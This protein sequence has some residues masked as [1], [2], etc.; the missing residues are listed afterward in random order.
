MS[1]DQSREERLAAQL[2]ANLRKRKA[3]AKG[4]AAKTDGESQNLLNK[5]ADS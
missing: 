2:R 4:M 1:N 5:P 3:Q